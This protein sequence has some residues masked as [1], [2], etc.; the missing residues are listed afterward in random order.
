[1]KPTVRQLYVC[2]INRLHCPRTHRMTCRFVAPTKGESFLCP[3]SKNAVVALRNYDAD[4]PR[5][6]LE[7]LRGSV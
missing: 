3:E 1:M 4:E 7:P 2:P 5:V 6:I